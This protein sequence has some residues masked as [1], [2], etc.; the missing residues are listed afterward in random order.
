MIS[1]FVRDKSYFMGD[2]ELKEYTDRCVPDP[3]NSGL[4]KIYW[5]TGIS[6]E[7]HPLKD[8]FSFYVCGNCESKSVK[9][10]YAKWAVHPMSGDVYWDYEIHCEDCGK[11]TTYSYAEND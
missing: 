5:G 3:D 11:Y 7:E 9:I 4:S 2:K 1:K 8:K 10:I 6:Y